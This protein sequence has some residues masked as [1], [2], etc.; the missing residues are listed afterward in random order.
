MHAPEGN[1][2]PRE[3]AKNRA[4]V[5]RHQPIND[6]VVIPPD[7][8]PMPKRVDHWVRRS[9]RLRRPVQRYD[10]SLQYIMLTDEGEPLTFREAKTCEHKSK[11]ELAMQEEIKAL[12]ANDTWDLV[13]LPKGRKAIPNKLVY[14]IKTVD[15][16][17]NYKAR[18]VAKGYA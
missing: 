8:D 4:I 3:H 16:K 7:V 13:V 9:T 18:L 6:D 15:G 12:H 1:L 10:P 2:Q 17:P 5:D 14:K 11:W